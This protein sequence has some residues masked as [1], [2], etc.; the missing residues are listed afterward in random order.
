MKQ[1]SKSLPLLSML[2]I[3]IMGAQKKFIFIFQSA[4][5]ILI[6]LGRFYHLIRKSFPLRKWPY[7]PSFGLFL[8]IF[9]Q[10]MKFFPKF[11]G[12]DSF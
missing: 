9:P 7:L 6:L 1:N 2:F 10:Q 11:N 12:T 5:K 8:K 3:Q 4:N